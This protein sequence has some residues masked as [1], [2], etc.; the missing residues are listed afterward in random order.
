MEIPAAEDVID[1]IIRASRSGASEAVLV[2]KLRDFG[3]PAEDAPAVLNSIRE[4]YRVGKGFGSALF[5]IPEQ[6]S[7]QGDP[8]FVTAYWRG[9]SAGF[10]RRLLLKIVPLVVLAILL[11]LGVWWLLA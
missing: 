11:F 6:C 10:K 7:A 8:F 5:V 9:F 4:G 3:C 2:G 1:T